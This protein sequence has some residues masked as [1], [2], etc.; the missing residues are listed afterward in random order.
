MM[1]EAIKRNV[2]EGTRLMGN[3]QTTVNCCSTINKLHSIHL[4]LISI[5]FYQLVQSE[6]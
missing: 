2:K 3:T 5:M 1:V 4:W 6:H